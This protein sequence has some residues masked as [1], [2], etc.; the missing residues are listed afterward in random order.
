[1]CHLYL[2]LCICV[3]LSLTDTY[4]QNTTVVHLLYFIMCPVV[5]FLRPATSVQILTAHFLNTSSVLCMF[6]ISI[7]FPSSMYV[8][9]LLLS[10]LAPAIFP[11]DDL[12]IYI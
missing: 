3:S 2:P 10:Y 11:S 4:T 12:R 6:L 5:L 8:L 1:M 9:Y 7:S